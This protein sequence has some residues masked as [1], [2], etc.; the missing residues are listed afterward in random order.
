[1]TRVTVGM[2]V[3]AIRGETVSG[4]VCLVEA[5]SRGVVVAAIDGLGHGPAAAAAS[6]A[7]VACLCAGLDAPLPE[8]FANAHQALRRTRGVVAVVARFDE[9][10]GSVEIAGL[11]NVS[12]LLSTGPFHPRHIV[13]PAGVIGG[14]FKQIRPQVLD[15]CP[16]DV[17]LLHTDGV[18]SRFDWTNLRCLSPDA[19]A[20]AIVTQHGMETDDAGCVVVVGTTS[21]RPRAP[22]SDPGGA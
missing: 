17:L 19:A 7:F 11:G 4:D 18:R 13:V 2:F 12:V 8:L 6:T 9:G 1:M 14:T 22:R 10:A 21:V 3:R 5:S 15:F 20:R 16:G